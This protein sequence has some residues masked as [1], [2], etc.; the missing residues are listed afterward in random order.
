[1]EQRKDWVETGMGRSGLRRIERIGKDRRK[2]EIFNKVTLQKIIMNRNQDK[3][4]CCPPPIFYQQNTWQVHFH[5]FIAMYHFFNHLTDVK[6][7][8]VHKITGFLR[9][10]GA[11][12]LRRI[13]NQAKTYK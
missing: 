13:E 4:I 7:S 5:C 6:K 11:W 3:K 1:M 9:Q 10:K 12:C 2:C 8:I